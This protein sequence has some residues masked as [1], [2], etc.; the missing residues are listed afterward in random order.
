MI[1]FAD[2]WQFIS[3]V[4]A[5]NCSNN[6]AAAPLQKAGVQVAPQTLTAV[7]SAGEGKARSA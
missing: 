4:S 2:D 7:S 5:D 3:A 6:L 1:P